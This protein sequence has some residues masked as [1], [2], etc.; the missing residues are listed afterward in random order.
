MD[1][2]VIGDV[3]CRLQKIRGSNADVI[4]ESQDFI[5]KHPGTEYADM[6]SIFQRKIISLTPDTEAI[7]EE[8]TELKSLLVEYYD[9]EID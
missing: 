9:G 6:V 7:T 2:R 3:I 8:I 5:T 1:I 4:K